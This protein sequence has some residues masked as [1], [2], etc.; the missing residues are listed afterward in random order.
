MIIPTYFVTAKGEIKEKRKEIKSKI[1]KIKTFEDN[2]MRSYFECGY[3]W[4]SGRSNPPATCAKYHKKI[5]E[6]NI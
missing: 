4:K 2:K 5:T 6:Y 3:E 1:K